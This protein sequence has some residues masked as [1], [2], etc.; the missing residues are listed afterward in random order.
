MQSEE[1]DEQ[2]EVADVEEGVEDQGPLPIQHLE[3][4]GVSASDVKKLNEA[5]YYTVESV[6]YTPRKQLLTIKGFAEAKVDKILAEAA[7]LVPMGFTTAADYHQKRSE[8][9]HITT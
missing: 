1:Y 5:G 9:M 3:Q 2:S 4:V 6:A 7:K 8:L